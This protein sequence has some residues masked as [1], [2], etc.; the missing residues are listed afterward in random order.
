MAKAKKSRTRYLTSKPDY[1]LLNS[2]NENHRQEF[3]RTMHYV[4]HEIQPKQITK[5]LILY[6]K[7][8]ELDYKLLNVLGDAWTSV[9][10]KYAYII[11]QGGELPEDLQ[12][13][14]DRLVGDNSRHYKSL[15]IHLRQ[16]GSEIK[17]K[18]L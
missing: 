13:G 17:H 14:F 16:N 11:N 7:N 3:H 15:Y 4:Q 10:G 6:A 18:D 1:T 8:A 9:A 12:I 5:A 2:K